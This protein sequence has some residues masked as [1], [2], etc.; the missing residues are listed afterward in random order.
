MKAMNNDIVTICAELERANRL[1]EDAL[2]TVVQKFGKST[3]EEF[4]IEFIARRT[5]VEAYVARNYNRTEAE[6]IASGQD[7]I[8]YRSLTEEAD[9]KYQSLIDSKEWSAAQTKADKSGAPEAF[10][11]ESLSADAMRIAFEC[12]Q[13]T[14]GNGEIICHGCGKPGHIVR[15]CPEKNSGGNPGGGGGDPNGGAIAEPGGRTKKVRW[16]NVPPKQ[17]DLKQKT[18]SGVTWYWCAL[19]GRWTKSHKTE[20]HSGPRND[21]ND[22][23]TTDQEGRR[24]GGAEGNV[25]EAPN[26]RSEAPDAASAGWAHFAGAW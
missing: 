3:V 18:I 10:N 21:A 19:C 14:N 17:N 4:R 12:H 5:G 8:T 23:A 6:V 22:G 15:F 16:Q 25:T 20:Q 2:V 1:P 13:A 9:A 26:D 11:V 7:L 24:G